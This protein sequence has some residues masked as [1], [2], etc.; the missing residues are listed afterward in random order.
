V[1]RRGELVEKRATQDLVDNGCKALPPVLI[2]RVQR[3]GVELQM[4]SAVQEVDD[5]ALACPGLAF[6]RLEDVVFNA[7]LLQEDHVGKRATAG[8]CAEGLTRVHVCVVG[9][10]PDTVLAELGN[11]MS[12]GFPS[13]R[14]V[15][16]PMNHA[17]AQVVRRR[18]ARAWVPNASREIEVSADV[19]DV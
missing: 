9:D 18:R 1:L 19:G 17:S 12:A 14:C 15:A 8:K 2:Q 11:I 4:R 10:V 7:C 16:V 13:G 3:C 6:L 5:E